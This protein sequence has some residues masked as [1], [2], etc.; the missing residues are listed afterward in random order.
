V[1]A[2]ASTKVG[3]GHHTYGGVTTVVE[4]ATTVVC[5]Y[6]TVTTKDGVVTSVVET[7]TYVCPSAGT[8]TIAPT[9][10]TITVDETIIVYPT[11]TEYCPGTYTAPAI[12]TTI[13]ETDVVIYCPWTSPTA[14]PEPEPKPS[15]VP[16]TA[17][18]P[19]STSTPDGPKLGGSGDRWAMTYTPYSGDSSGTCKSAGEVDADIQKIK[20]SGFSVVRVY[21]TD[22]NTLKNVG[23][24]CSKYGLKM[25]IGVFVREAG[26]DYNIA[27]IKEQVDA[28]TAWARWDLVE[29]VVV[30]NECVFSGKCSA[31]SLKNLIVTVR[32]KCAAAGYHGSF[33]T[34]ET[35]GVWQ[36]SDVQSQICGVIDIVGGQIHPYFNAETSASQ[37]GTFVAGQLSILDGICGGKTALNLE[38]GWPSA[39][40][41]NG[42]ACPGKSEQAAAIASIKDT[43]GSRTV[44]FSFHN[45]EWKDAGACGCEKSWGCGDLF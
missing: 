42:K 38:C 19:K 4:T 35:V 26:C 14:V 41:C 21:S 25:I 8:Y 32:E 10:T 6:A 9:T 45:D 30:G 37:A 13:T 5:P 7:T 12:V 24:A 3:K 2:P 34:A 27:Y 1:C 44:F 16:D 20:N 15:K 22:C 18:P 31:S 40:N 36:Q 43:C 39:G 23:D 33:T 17:E 29:L 28:I 11:V